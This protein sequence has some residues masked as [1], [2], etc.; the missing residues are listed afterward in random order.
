MAQGVFKERLDRLVPWAPLDHVGL[1]GKSD[2]KALWDLPVL[3]AR[4]ALKVLPVS[5]GR[6]VPMGSLD[7]SIS[8]TK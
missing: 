1:M 4:L 5:E 3:M 2:L 8:I 6:R 7:I